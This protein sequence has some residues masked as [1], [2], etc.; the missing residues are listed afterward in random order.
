V[1]FNEAM[2]TAN[3]T[4][5]FNPGTA[6][7]LTFAS[8]A[9][10]V[11]NTVYT[12]TYNVIDANV[13]IADISVGVTGARD[14]QGNLQ[15][16]YTPEIELSIDTKNPV[17]TI[18]LDAN[19]SGDGLITTGEAAG[20]V[21]IT[22]SAGGDAKDGDTVTLTIN[23]NSGY[24][25][26]VTGGNFSILVAGADLA[27][28]PDKTIAA[29]ITST[30][31]A[32]NIGTAV[33]TESYRSLAGGPGNDTLIGGPGNDVFQGNAGDDTLIG[34]SG[35]DTLDGGIDNDTAS[36]ATATAGVIASLTTTFT[37]GPP[38]AQS[39]DALGDTFTSIENL[40]G[41]AHNDT[42]IGDG[43]NNILTGSTGDDILEGMAG[44]DELDG[45]SGSDTASYIHAG[46][47]VIASLA[48][49]GDNTNDA[50]ADTY[51]SIENLTGSNFADSLSGDGGSNILIGGLG[52]DALE[53]RGG[54][55]TLI[56]G[57]GNDTASY[58]RAATAVFASLDTSFA[59]LQTGDASGDTF[60]S[61]EN[62][63]GSAFVDTLIGNSG[64]NILTAGDGDDT[65]E[66][67]GGG[68]ELIGGTGND[69]ASYN[70]SSSGKV[71]S[72]ATPAGNS[73]DAGNDTYTSIENLTGSAYNDT[74]S[75]DGGANILIGG[76]GGD[77]M[78]GGGGIDTA[79]YANAATSVIAALTASLAAIQ[80]GDA[81][82]DSFSGIANLSG[83]AHNDTLIGNEFSNTLNGGSGDDILEGM[84][85]AD[86]LSGGAGNNTASYEHSASG[87]VASLD[88]SFAPWQ[89][90]TPSDAKDDTYENIQNL[91]G[92]GHDDVLIGDSGNNILAGGIGIDIIYA[93]QGH[94][95]AY[96]GDNNDTFYVSSLPVNL[97]TII[98]GGARDGG[99]GNVMVLQNLVN[100][101]SYN[102]ATL[103][104][105]T[106]NIDT[107]SI[108]GDSAATALT[109]SS[110][111]L[112]NMVDNGTASQLS[113]KADSGDTLNI[114][115][116]AGETMTP[117]VI[118]ATHTDY[119]VFNASHTQIGQIH[120]H[121]A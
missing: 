72:L 32:G 55:D 94:D 39:G 54:A 16:S 58:A 77:I 83:S 112:Q 11:G 100:G 10:S 67:R 53:G 89:N 18:T 12:A 111:D 64:A 36:Y 82:G 110:Q 45:G 108:R 40:I 33:D 121:T 102:M 57:N 91:T 41:S 92:S 44:A 75:G 14:A 78:A 69:T 50:A 76:A 97:P 56:G 30:D 34:N 3:P 35:A 103:A 28:D 109:I 60:T 71:A 98:D 96:G 47:G 48:N 101:G 106:S 20:N 7:S 42:L 17:P 79:S 63:T 51:V 22:G 113:I 38:V 104:G 68:D 107:L 114:S 86:H 93:N 43:I 120:W 84:A 19:I 118:D 37:V 62:L 99:D 29:S 105:V 49:P 23:G 74:L 24:T 90:A 70:H 31:T 80:T 66:G 25:G 13:E 95:S 59:A 15:Q 52:N 46:V 21:I 4:L 117:A 115:L 73:G 61:I 87:V 65:L 85:G 2:N 116:A 81:F 119:T 1:T 88:S 8:G 6:G 9:W 27:A 5:T 26:T